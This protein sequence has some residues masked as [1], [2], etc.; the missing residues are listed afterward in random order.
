MALLQ[1][2]QLPHVPPSLTLHLALYHELQNAAFLQRQLLEGKNDFE[3][4]F[5]DASTVG[6][7]SGPRE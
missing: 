3:Y 7:F 6:N 2:L 1:T 5:I 4:A